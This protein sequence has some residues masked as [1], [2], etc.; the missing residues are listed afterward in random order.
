MSTFVADSTYAALYGNI[1]VGDICFDPYI[2]DNFNGWL[3]YNVGT[4]GPLE[5]KKVCIRGMQSPSD[6]YGWIRMTFKGATSTDI[7]GLVITN[8]DGQVRTTSSLS[9]Y[10]LGKFKVTGKYDP[11][12]QTGDIN[13]QGRDGSY[14]WSQFGFKLSSLWY[15]KDTYGTGE[16]CKISETECVE[17]TGSSSIGFVA[18]NN[19]VNDAAGGFMTVSFHDNWV[20][21]VH[22]EGVYVGD[23]G[24]STDQHSVSLTAYNNVFERSGY[25]CF[26]SGRLS[27]G[28]RIYNNVMNLASMGYLTNEFM[29][30]QDYNIQ[31]GSRNNDCKFYNNMCIGAGFAQLFIAEDS[32]GD[33]ENPLSGT[34]WEIYNN[35]FLFGRNIFTQIAGTNPVGWEKTIKIR[36]N[37]IGFY[38]YTYDRYR[39]DGV[40]GTWI[41]NWHNDDD[42]NIE[43]TDN[44][45]GDEGWGT[46]LISDIGDAVGN[47]NV[48]TSG[49]L[50]NQVTPRPLFINS[51]FDDATENY[52]KHEDWGAFIDVPGSPNNGDPITFPIGYTVYH[53]MSVY[54]A[55]AESHDV[56]PEVTAGWTNYWDKI[57]FDGHNYPAGDLRAVTGSEYEL[58][59]IGLLDKYTAPPVD[60]PGDVDSFGIKTTMF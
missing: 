51:G 2:D 46:N 57:T 53:N 33:G 28:S 1:N 50:F 15:S 30:S 27:S 12:A 47:T 9:I 22:S 43:I 29:A 36:D 10:G 44:K 3:S 37:I 39:T 4:H 14:E 21:D 11:I 31:Q 45:F 48:S 35:A 23:T 55:T 8:Y 16:P 38:Y 5:G 60:P 19:G 52:G 32:E 17:I 7:D 13:Y 40:T 26:Q 42:T 25:E 18:K 54:L 6:T 24:T 49:N 20:H 41:G 58:L 56:E 34:G 59:D